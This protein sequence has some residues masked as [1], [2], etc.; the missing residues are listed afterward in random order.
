[1]TETEW[2]AKR[3]IFYNQ[4]EVSKSFITKEQMVIEVLQ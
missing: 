4:W 1:M 2:N 3:F